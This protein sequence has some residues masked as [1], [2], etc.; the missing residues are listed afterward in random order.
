MLILS[1]FIV[2]IEITVQTLPL[3]VDGQ[4][5]S[6]LDAELYAVHMDYARRA[7]EIIIQRQV[8][9][10][11]RECELRGLLQARR[12]NLASIRARHGQ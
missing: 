4:G 5:M 3:N 11:E 10:P 7:D 12:E 8:S 6:A 1:C 9:A 2:T